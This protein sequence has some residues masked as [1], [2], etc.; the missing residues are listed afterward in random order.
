M[1]L[2]KWIRPAGQERTWWTSKGSQG[3]VRAWHDST[4]S[5]RD[6][7][8]RFP[9]TVPGN[10]GGSHCVLD[11]DQFR[12]ENDETTKRTDFRSLY[13]GLTYQ[14]KVGSFLLFEMCEMCLEMDTFVINGQILHTFCETPKDL[15]HWANVWL[16][17]F[18]HFSPF[19]EWHVYHKEVFAFC[20][21]C[22]FF[23]AL[24]GSTSW[25]LDQS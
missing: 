17:E 19:S 25:I 23:V 4:L 12:V 13:W 1:I 10:I 2:Q 20:S 6:L 15:Q 7:I 18:F 22:P 24:E 11:V 9:Q 16:L 5:Y 21:C 14:D 3:C 8:L